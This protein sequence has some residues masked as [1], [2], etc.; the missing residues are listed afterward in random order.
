[1]LIPDA[2]YDVEYPFEDRGAISGTY[3]PPE[4]DVEGEE[5]EEKVICNCFKQ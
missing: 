5:E 3:H 4:V 1:M 2:T